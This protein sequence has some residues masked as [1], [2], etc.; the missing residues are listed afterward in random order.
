MNVS[1]IALRVFLA[2]LL[3][4]GISSVR[5]QSFRKTYTPQG[6]IAND[7][8]ETAGGGF[9]MAGSTADTVLFLQR[10]DA[11][12]AIR[13][14]QHQYFNGARGIAVCRSGDGGFA[15]LCENYR[16]GAALRNVVLKID[17][18]GATSWVKILQNPTLAN[19]YTD[20]VATADGGFAL[21]GDGRDFLPAPDFFVRL[22]KLDASGALLW[23]QTFGRSNTTTE[24][25]RRL[26]ELPNGDLALAG[27]IRAGG[28]PVLNGAD[29]W[30]ARTDAGGNILWQNTYPKPAYQ[31][32]RDFLTAP[33]GGLVILGESAQT[34]PMTMTLL[35]TGGD[36]AELW[37]QQPLALANGTVPVINGSMASC[38][39]RDNSGNMYVPVLSSMDAATTDLSLLKISN[40]GDSLWL[41][42][43]G[44]DDFFKAA[45]YTSDDHFAFCGASSFGWSGGPAVL[46]KTDGLNLNPGF[47]NLLLG[48]VY[49]DDNANCAPDSGESGAPLLFV[50]ARDPQGETRLQAVQPDGTYAMM[51]N[52][53][54]YHL[55]VRTLSGAPPFWAVCDTPVV[56]VSGFNQTAQA[57]PIGVQ[58]AGP[59]PYLEVDLKSGPLR[60]CTTNYWT[61]NYCNYGNLAAT[62]ASVQLSVDPLLSYVSSNIPLT[63]Q[64]G[65][66]YT[67]NIP[68]VQPG[69]CGW[70]QVQFLLGCDAVNGQSICAEAHIFPDSLC[71]PD[72]PLWDGSHVELT[73]G[74][75]G[76]VQFTVAN[77]GAGMTGP[78][79]YVIIEDQIMYQMGQ[80]QLPAGADTAI[81][82]DNPVANGSYYLRVNQR[83]GHPGAGQPAV[84]ADHCNGPTTS[85]LSLQLPLG[86]DDPYLDIHC[87]LV[88]GSFDPND[89]RG[90]PLGWRPQHYIE[91]NQD[92]EYLIRFQN[93]GNDTAFLVIIRDQLPPQLDPLSIR[94]GA[95]SHPYRFEIVGNNQLSFTFPNIQLP[96]STTNE[97]A[98]H[99]FVS[100]SV[101]QKPNLPPGTLIEN[102]AAI[103]F[104]FNDPIITDP[105]R[106]VVGRPLLTFIIDRP[107]TEA[108]QLDILPNPASE[109]AL[110][111]INNLLPDSEQ[112]FR[113]FDSRGKLLRTGQFSGPDYHFQRSGLPAG[114]YHFRIETK[115]G[116]R[117]SGKL[118]LR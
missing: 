112:F 82:V 36:G 52:A 105:Y 38:F 14:T 110:F 66:T 9:L 33:D 94:P 47:A 77:T 72:D 1:R 57:P 54:T 85:S 107:S 44:L 71:G 20:I 68:D 16:D 35:K 5:G 28:A 114:L 64:S 70:F 60:R 8:V 53:G 18:A 62:H 29:F 17:S 19:G 30:L 117:A 97:A 26:A 23:E 81:T 24:L 89:K 34:D 49:R 58:G 32:I 50:E 22:L 79:D 92:I 103:Y 69:D 84:V 96:D 115:E 15:V 116:R 51:V 75:N 83:P 113:L 55:Y 95:A 39:T 118:I 40:S 111:R 88:I 93:T 59:C 42:D 48:T 76:G 46:V 43:F 87:D 90:F 10:T 73:A 27:E 56:V 67:F 109:Q 41:H 99:G 21:V 45:I 104:D 3:S 98:S 91:A 63:A 65:D 12:G 13:W 7:L 78:C 74:C 37:Y 4:I 80:I 86:D 102:E 106:H 25:G 6:S 108:L 101:S 11:A 61:V 2:L 31:R 100:F